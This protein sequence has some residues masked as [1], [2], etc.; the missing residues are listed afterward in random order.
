M[1]KKSNK[2]Q[3]FKFED[4][5][6]YQKALIFT[7][8][9]YRLTD[10]FPESEKYGLISQFRRATTSIALNIAEGYGASKKEFGRYLGISHR[11]GNECV[12]CAS[13]AQ[14]LG[15][16]NDDQNNDV[17]NSVSEI[18]KMISGLKRSWK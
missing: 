6:V 18:Q 14:Q 3:H 17:R 5:K 1:E 11:S 7:E 9:V 10:R 13:I 2:E 4:L 15:Y 12:V 8:F 16:I